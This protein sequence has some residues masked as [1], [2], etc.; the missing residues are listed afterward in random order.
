MITD[1]SK[2]FVKA[3]VTSPPGE[4]HLE[5]FAGVKR[6]TIMTQMI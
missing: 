5:I 4:E 2:A 1:I 6:A 3:P